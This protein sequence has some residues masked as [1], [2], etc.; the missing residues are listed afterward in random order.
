MRPDVLW[1][2][3]GFSAQG[4]FGAR[5]VVQWW[6]SERAGMSVM[7]VSFWYLSLFGSMLLLIYALHKRDAVF[8]AGQLAGSLIYLRNLYLIRH[9]QPTE[10]I[11]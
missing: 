11:V 2:T 5:F 1:L 8:I 7:P 4:V 3:L 6:R 9:K 10:Q